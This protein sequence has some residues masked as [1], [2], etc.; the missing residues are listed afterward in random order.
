MFKIKAVKMESTHATSLSIVVTEASLTDVFHSVNLNLS[1][2]IPPVDHKP[3]PITTFP[4]STVPPQA[5]RRLQ[6]SSFSLGNV[7]KSVQ[8]KVQTLGSDV[9]AL[10]DAVTVAQHFFE[11]GLSYQS[12]TQ[13][14]LNLYS[15]NVDNATHA[16]PECQFAIDKLLDTSHV[17]GALTGTCQSCYAYIGVTIA[18]SINIQQGKLTD[19][20]IIMNGT[21]TF[22]STVSLIINASDL[23]ISAHIATLAAG[24]I[25]FLL[26]SIPIR[27]TS[28]TPIR[29]GVSGSDT[30]NFQMSG[31]MGMSASVNAGFQIAN[32]QTRFINQLNFDHSGSGVHLPGLAAVL[33]NKY[34][35]ALRLY[36]L[37][38]PAI[39][40]DYLGGPKVGLKT[41]LEGVVD[42]GQTVYTDNTRTTT[43]PNRHCSSGPSV[44][45]NAGLDGTVG[46]DIHIGVGSYQVFNHSYPSLATFSLHHAVSPLYCPY[47]LASSSSSGRRLQQIAALGPWA[48]VGNIWQGKQIYT[49]A[50]HSKCDP[51]TIP[52]FVLV[53]LQLVAVV[54]TG[55]GPSLDFLATITAEPLTSAAAAMLS[56]TNRCTPWTAMMIGNSLPASLPKLMPRIMWGHPRVVL[57]QSHCSF[58][59]RL[60]P[61]TGKLRALLLP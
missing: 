6:A 5:R 4:A 22:Q 27:L 23:D 37:P 51:S 31:D 40:F 50:G 25:E 2:A 3:Q 59:I 58:S 11:N 17:G 21:A 46:A 7:L 19:A 15:F 20:S 10:I 53:S 1:A 55:S 29:L 39:N 14:T 49:G 24:P 33:S 44:V 16:G 42:S 9:D 56:S 18:A 52:P 57:V 60:E 32:S 8:A 45:A 36:I 12:A 48:Q 34:S 30:G 47:G 41:Y 28:S 35:A 61:S 43:T 13:E 38:A 26:G 54:Q